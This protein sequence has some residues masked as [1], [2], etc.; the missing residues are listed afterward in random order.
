[1]PPGRPYERGNPRGRKGVKEAVPRGL[2]KRLVFAVV[3][4]NEELIRKTLER[5]ATNPKTVLQV[6]ELAARLNRETGPAADVGAA[7]T[8]LNFNT[9]VNMMA[10]RAAAVRA[11]NPVP[12]PAALTARA[13]TVTNGLKNG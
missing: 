11:V 10:L 5:A 7:G 2:V 8:V 12:A 13:S 4:E 9:N 1:M 3:T 6:L